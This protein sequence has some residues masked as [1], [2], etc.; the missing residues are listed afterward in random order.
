MKWQIFKMK[1]YVLALLLLMAC[2]QHCLTGAVGDFTSPHEFNK[3][4]EFYKQSVDEFIKLN[5]P[6][7]ESF[8]NI[9][10]RVVDDLQEV[11]NVDS[12]SITM[13]SLAYS[14]M[15]KKL[16][17]YQEP[18]VQNAFNTCE[19]F[20]IY[21]VDKADQ[22]SDDVYFKLFIKN[23]IKELNASFKARFKEYFDKFTK[24]FTQYL[25]TF[26]DVEKND[27]KKVFDW[28]K[29]FQGEDVVHEKIKKFVEYF[30]FFEK[31]F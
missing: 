6:L 3:N 18:N 10:D 8:A 1:L 26:S 5:Q 14:E 24:D 19:I 11:P 29:E 23:G 17:S 15:A 21:D 27:N 2:A 22:N 20:M 25:G 12:Y 9:L 4:N 28:F 7:G 16:R 30:G 31:L 13:N